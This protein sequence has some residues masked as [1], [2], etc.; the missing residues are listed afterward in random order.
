[1]WAA[2]SVGSP[3]R[4]GELVEAV[5][6]GRGSGASGFVGKMSEMSWIRRAFECIR[7]EKGHVGPDVGVSEISDHLTTAPDYCYFMDNTDVLAVD[8]DHVEQY[9]WP[10][11][12]SAF[13]L[14]E[15]YFHAMQ[16]AFQFVLREQFLAVL[17]HLPQ[18]A[19]PSWSQRHWLA[20]AN[21]V[22]AV[23]SLWLQITK[24]DR[25]G[26]RDHHLM[27]YARARALGIDHRIM[28]DHPDIERVQAIGLLSFYL[29]VN[30]SVTR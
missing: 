5:D 26:K 22:W 29:L 11:G 28:F 21:L 20:M 1:M 30:G 18:Q 6:L 17:V 19:M 3:G 9:D 13:I 27:Y 8:E 10:P 25:S 16:G 12:D 15:A 14:A 7:A 23:G 2:S 24:L 4:Q